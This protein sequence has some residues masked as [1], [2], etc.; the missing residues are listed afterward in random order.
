MEADVFVPFV[1]FAFLGAII[2][3]PV[4]AKERTKRSAHDLIAQ[5]MSRGQ[6]LEPSLV[7]QLTQNMLEEGNRARQSLGSGVIL[8]ALAGGFVA[9][10]F[11]IEGFDHHDG[12]VIRGFAVPAVILGTVGV[13]FLF[14]AIIDYASRKKHTSA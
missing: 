11:V 12:D 10:G 3:V 1:F 6:P 13:A 2:L 7:S 8:L 9:A 5:A 14:L 4:L